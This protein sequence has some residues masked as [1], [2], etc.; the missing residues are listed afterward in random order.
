MADH[1]KNNTK[2]E[3]E[4]DRA[5]SGD[6]RFGRSVVA[7]ENSLAVSRQLLLVVD[8][9]KVRAIFRKLACDPKYMQR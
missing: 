3:R 8:L 2:G 7:G 1:L 6:E 5:A 4:G 9:P